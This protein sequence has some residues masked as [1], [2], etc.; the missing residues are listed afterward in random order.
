M[1]EIQQVTWGKVPWYLSHLFRERDR[2]H[3]HMHVMCVFTYVHE[4]LHEGAL[5]GQIWTI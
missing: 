3:E 1:S 4:S 5:T 2:E